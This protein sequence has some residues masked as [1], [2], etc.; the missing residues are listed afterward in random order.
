MTSGQNGFWSPHWCVELALTVRQGKEACREAVVA[1]ASGAC[2]RPSREP[3]EGCAC[4]SILGATGT[5][6]AGET[7]LA[8]TTRVARGAMDRRSCGVGLG[9][10]H[11]HAR[12]GAYSSGLAR[13]PRSRN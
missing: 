1:E 9:A 5:G 10:D 4:Q 13:N 8:E 11:D 12:D 2:S 6:A 7:H 3:V